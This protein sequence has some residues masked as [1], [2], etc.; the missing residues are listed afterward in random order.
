M[1]LKIRANVY[2]VVD[3]PG[4]WYGIP[5]RGPIKL[6]QIKKLLDSKIKGFQLI[7]RYVDAI[8][9]APPD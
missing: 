4:P 8:L 2:E 7:E 1:G 6:I 9:P 3:K 5:Y